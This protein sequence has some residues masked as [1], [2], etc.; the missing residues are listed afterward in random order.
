MSE[1]TTAHNAIQSKPQQVPAS[2]S[3]SRFSAGHSSGNPFLTMQHSL[4]NQ[5]MLRLLELGMIQPKFRLSQ[6][7]DPD[8]LEADHVADRI[9]AA[10]H[11]PG[12]QRK[13]ACEGS[14]S[15]R[16]NYEEE[17]TGTI[18]RSVVSPLLRFTQLSLQRAPADSA[19]T[20]T[21]D[22]VGNP[23]KP[24]PTPAHSHP[25]VVED[26]AKS[27]APHQMRKSAFIALLR[28]DAC[29]TADAVLESV[30]RT[31]KSC[32]YIEKWLGFYEKQSSDHI[33]RAILKYAPE[34]ASAR[35]AHEAIRLVL[36]RVQRA[37][38]TWAK[39]G[40]L[41]GLPEDLASQIPG[42]GGFLGAIRNFASSG[43]GGSILGFIGGTRPEK[44]AAEND[45]GDSSNAT[46][47]R[48]ASDG[49]AAPAHDAG[50]VRS[51]LGTGHSLDSRVQS[52][53]S[54]AFGRDF[55]GVRIHTDSRAKALSSDLNARAFTV[56][57]D[58]AFASGEYRPGTLIGDALIAHELA[59]V[60]QQSAAARSSPM[61]KAAGNG[62]DST[63]HDSSHLEN[64]A[65]LFAVGAVASIWTGAKR[66]LADLRQNAIPRLRSGLRL[67]RCAHKSARSPKAP[68]TAPTTTPAAPATLRERFDRHE[69]TQDDLANPDVKAWIHALTKNQLRDYLDKTRDPAV[70]AYINRLL[71]I[72]TPVPAGATFDDTGI[73]SLTLGNVQVLILPDIAVAAG[74]LDTDV[75]TSIKL[76]GGA[77]HLRTTK[78]KK[79]L[80][81]FT[82]GPWTLTIQTKFSPG[83]SATD[84]SGYGRGTTQEDLAAKNTSVGF[85]E[86]RH[87]LAALD[88][89]S[90]HPPPTFGGTVGM[91]QKQYEAE[92]KKFDKAFDSYRIALHRADGPPVDC[93]GKTIEV[94]Y[95]ENHKKLKKEYQCPKH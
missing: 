38:I 55:S 16:S 70:Q 54:A 15:P 52:Q 36:M 12:F 14:G 7:G 60:V 1:K 19:S 24:S 41:I 68:T 92:E 61:S 86:G 37:T 83:I 9:V 74:V 80:K 64:E 31:T 71:A 18:H 57:S 23:P 40:K 62:A 11:S 56:G 73:A 2:A 85:H 77:L 21:P 27:V 49:G 25:L 58:V 47:A 75:A 89:I 29:A 78:D 39:T 45:F 82:Q 84:T 43:V 28:T 87:G 17:R 33:E 88:F 10:T 81:E 51:H 59:H 6:P 65:D 90:Q 63:E 94:Y 53:M 3:G 72:S 20:N 76:E 35:S 67:Q 30:G 13:C 5:A 79:T 93:V 34:T 4:G 42:Q 66:G 44:S 95:H 8:E 50:A 91:N 46:V 22:P 26:D 32:P 48:K 69:I